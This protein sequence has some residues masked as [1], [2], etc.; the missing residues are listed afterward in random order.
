MINLLIINVLII[1]LLIINGINLVL[2][3]SKKK[4]FNYIKENKFQKIIKNSIILKKINSKNNK[5]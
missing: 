2:L 4:K 3:I 1:N 5:K